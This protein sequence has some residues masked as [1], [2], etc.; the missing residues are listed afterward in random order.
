MKIRLA[1]YVDMQSAHYLKKEFCF[2]DRKHRCVN[3]FVTLAA[4]IYHP[5][6]IYC[7]HEDTNNGKGFAVF[8][9]IHIKKRT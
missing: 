1:K 8:S 6:L 5:L 9:I 3:E 7:K 4:S 2:F